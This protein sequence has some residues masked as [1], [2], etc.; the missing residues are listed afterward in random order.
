M[1]TD[2]KP[3][4][5]VE[6][7]KHGHLFS[8]VEPCAKCVCEELIGE[9]QPPAQ[10]GGEEKQD[11][12]NVYREAGELKAGERF[13][14]ADTL[15]EVTENLQHWPNTVT[16]FNVKID[17]LTQIGKS[18]IVLVANPNKENDELCDQCAVGFYLPSGVCDHC[19]LPRKSKPSPQPKPLASG[20]WRVGRILLDDDD[21]VWIAEII[22]EHGWIECRTSG[23]TLKQE[24]E[25][26]AARIV[27]DHGK[28]DLLLNILA[29][30]HR[31]GGHY[32]AAHRLSKAIEDADRIVAEL[33]CDNDSL[34]QERDQL[35]KQIHDLKEHIKLISLI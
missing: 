1:N 19:N 22:N 27:E 25:Q 34:R 32:V 6:S 26:T 35:L 7:C 16:I 28:S 15:F 5:P 20:E 29:R 33:N 12:P 8:D 14:H 4:P 11:W 17:A 23:R 9:P 2:P 3:Q 10:S 21:L 24:C 31:D 18:V 13:V 30:I